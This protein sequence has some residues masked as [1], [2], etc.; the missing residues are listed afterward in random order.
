M[1]IPLLSTK[2]KAHLWGGP[3]DRFSQ[4]SKS[5]YSHGRSTTFQ[6]YTSHSHTLYNEKLLRVRT[7]KWL[8]KVKECLAVNGFP[9]HSCGM[10][11]AIRDRT[12]LPATRHKWTHP[13]L[14]PASWYSIYLPRRDGRL[15]W[16]R[17]PG[18]APAGIRT[19]DL[20]ITSPTPY[21]YT[22]ESTQMH[23]CQ[24][25]PCN[26]ESAWLKPNCVDSINAATSF[27]PQSKTLPPRT[28][29][30]TARHCSSCDISS[31]SARRPDSNFRA[32][33]FSCCFCYSH[34]SI[35]GWY[36]TTPKI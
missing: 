19:R 6:L 9:S 29:L 24:N 10:S 28:P 1:S 22:T 35:L 14:T 3:F 7:R 36:Y 13:A 2:I 8:K 33:S 20:S 11:L 17:L 4:L 12:V 25:V 5:S 23:N 32:C 15:S 21:H 30:T 31:I 27:A 26:L 18:N 16:P 34:T